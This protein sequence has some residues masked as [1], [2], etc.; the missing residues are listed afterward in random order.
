MR[1]SYSQ[2][3]RSDL[4]PMDRS[5][6]NQVSGSARE[7]ELGLLADLSGH[8]SESA[9]GEWEHDWIDLGGEG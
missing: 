7:E 3:L 6:W 1:R 8:Q 9:I 5:G 2:R 4:F